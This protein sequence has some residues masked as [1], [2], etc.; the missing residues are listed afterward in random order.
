MPF[1]PAATAG[2]AEEGRTLGAFA[3]VLLGIAIGVPA[4]LL[5]GKLASS[6]LYGVS[7]YNTL[8]LASTA[9][10]L[11][12]AA[13]VAALVPATSASHIEPMAALRAE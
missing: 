7:P 1:L 2:G 11:A 4:A 12:L 3:Q 9:L 6:E 10:I 13:F 8:V 5:G